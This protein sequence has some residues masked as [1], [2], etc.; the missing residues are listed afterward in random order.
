MATGIGKSL[1]D[2]SPKTNL[3]IKTLVLVVLGLLQALIT[4]LIRL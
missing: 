1:T 4:I 3:V 2:K